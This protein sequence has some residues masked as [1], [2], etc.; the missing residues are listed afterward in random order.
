M[1]KLI[2]LSII[3]IVG[4]APATKINQTY[5][6]K[7]DYDNMFSHGT[8]KVDVKGLNDELETKIKISTSD[9][10]N[11]MMF[12]QYLLVVDEPDPFLR[13]Y[14]DKATKRTTLELYVKFHSKH[15]NY[16]NTA[17]L[18]IENQ[19]KIL[20]ATLVSSDVD[21]SS[22]RCSYYEDAV[23]TLERKWLD[24]WAKFGKRIRFG[25]TKT[26][27]TQDAIIDSDEI[28]AFLNEVDKF[29]Q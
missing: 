1:K 21:C 11:K 27:Y 9:Y 6:E 12:N 2:I 4:C 24:E 14:I 25:S 29:S 5:G 7:Y 17:T 26:D 23:L 28:K 18:K 3:L 22:P 16:W 15:W 13:A 10:S 20:E 19:I 8:K